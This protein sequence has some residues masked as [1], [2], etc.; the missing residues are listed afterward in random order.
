M[1]AILH[2]PYIAQMIPLFITN[3]P[4]PR[5]YKIKAQSQTQNKAFGQN[6]CAPRVYVDLCKQVSKQE[7]HGGPGIAHLYFSPT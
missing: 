6:N 2:V 5:G 7:D 1:A 4:R 3:A